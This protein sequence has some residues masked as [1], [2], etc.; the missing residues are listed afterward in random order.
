MIMFRV[1]WAIAT[2]FAVYLFIHG[3]GDWSRL[4]QLTQ[5][6][7]LLLGIICFYFVPTVEAARL[8]HYNFGAIFMTNLLLGWTVLGWIVALIWSM[9][10]P[11]PERRDKTDAKKS[12]AN[13]GGFIRWL[14][15]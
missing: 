1:A 12:K 3:G 5:G 4:D 10:K 13:R 14:F 11:P 15:N 8:R 2:F 6:Q 7:I 9:T